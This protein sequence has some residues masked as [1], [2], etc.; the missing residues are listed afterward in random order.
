MGSRTGLAAAL[1][2]IL[3][4]SSSYPVARVGIRHFDPL[5]FS[6]LRIVVAAGFLALIASPL[7]VGLPARGDRWHVFSSGIVGVTVYLALLNSGLEVVESAAAAVLLA[8]A[9]IF[10]ALMSMGFIGERLTLWGWIGLGGAFLGVVLVS[11]GQGS[12]VRLGVSG[13]LVMLAAIA[14]AAYNV[15]TKPLASR[16]RPVQVV[17]WVFWSGALTSVPLLLRAPAQLL[18]APAEGYFSAIYLGLCASALGYILWTRALA[19]APVSV[20]ASALYITPPLSALIGW[21]WLHEQPSQS[22]L[23]GGLVILAGVVLVM[24]RGVAT[25]G[26][27]S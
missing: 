13:L 2:T 4:W 1:V 17:T 15:M 19:D 3:V 5:V 23:V 27:P 18:A 26:H 11:L 22:V 25:V 20:V 12:G 8:L 10:V 14:H 21:V 9:P 16:Y 7:R 24:R 6:A